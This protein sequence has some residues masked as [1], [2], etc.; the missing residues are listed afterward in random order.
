[1]RTDA[2]TRYGPYLIGRIFFVRACWIGVHLGPPIDS[3]FAEDTV[4]CRE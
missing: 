3:L 2:L 1:M 4:Q